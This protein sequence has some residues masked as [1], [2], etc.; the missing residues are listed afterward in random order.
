ME[1]WRVV[2]WGR[3]CGLQDGR[4]GRVGSSFCIVS[5]VGRVFDGT[6]HGHKVVSVFDGVSLSAE[7]TSFVARGR[8]KGL[9]QIF[10]RRRRM[11][12]GEKLIFLLYLG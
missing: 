8:Q 4:E 9:P 7:G 1:R 3:A 2:V 10:C 5:D 12:K 11:M 6:V